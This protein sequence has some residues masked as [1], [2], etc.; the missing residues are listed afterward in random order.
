MTKDT[1]VKIQHVDASGN[2]TILKDS[3]KLLDKEIIDASFMSVKELRS[4][5]AKEFDDG[6]KESMLVSLHLKATMMKISDPIIFGHAV[7]TFFES[8]FV[9]HAELFKELKIN[10][11]NGLAEVTLCIISFSF[12]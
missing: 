2:V 1:S 10:P 6:F 4:F 3:L 7:T 11:N 5:L 8:V 12:P 9:K